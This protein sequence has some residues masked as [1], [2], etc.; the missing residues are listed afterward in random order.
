MVKGSWPRL[1]GDLSHPDQLWGEHEA[2]RRIVE[3]AWEANLGAESVLWRLEAE[4]LSRGRIWHGEVREAL[5][6]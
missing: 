2:W 1:V 6:K 4:A 5:G 3:V